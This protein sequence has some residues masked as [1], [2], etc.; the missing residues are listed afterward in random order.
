[1]ETRKTVPQ[2]RTR[3]RVEEG[4]FEDQWGFAVIVKVRG[5][6]KER[7]F[8]PTTDRETLRSARIQLR[9]E[10]DQDRPTPESRGTFGAAAEAWLARKRGMPCYKAER[11]H[12]K[13]WPFRETPLRAVTPDR[14]AALVA[15]WKSE[16]VAARTIRHRVRV[17]REIYD[18]AKAPAPLG[19]AQ[20]PPIPESF[21]VAVPATT[22]RRVIKSLQAAHL[23]LHLA[24]FAVRATTGQRPVQIG[25]A[26]P[27][28]IDWDRKLWYVRSAKGGTPVPLP[29]SEEALRA[30]R[31]FANANAW[32]P[33]DTSNEARRLRNH[34][35]PET[36]R[37]YACRSTFAI[38]LLLGGADLGDV[39]G[40][41]GHRQIETT[42]RHYA[43]LLTSRLA[44]WTASRRLGLPA[45]TASRAAPKGQKV[46][47]T[48]GG[49][50]AGRK[51]K[52]R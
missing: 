17:L 29:L 41:L 5:V 42:R 7:R 48:S 14:V 23:D 44:K 8:P 10:L 11:S 26:Q 2:T 37:P 49:R 20:V 51:A 45:L 33:Y 28:D 52:R 13:A 3:V 32:G 40:L 15:T 9:A 12:Q 47:E 25:L 31:F 35:W 16:A 4:I 39:Q 6:T 1:M 19:A 21:P 50:S 46:E 24:R 36:V 30:W 27:T 18:G 43:P 38:D 22:I 34:G